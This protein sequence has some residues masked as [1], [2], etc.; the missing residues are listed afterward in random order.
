[1]NSL[2]NIRVYIEKMVHLMSKVL[3][4]DVLISDINHRIIGDGSRKGI[5]CKDEELE[6]L[7]NTSVI[8]LAIKE[9]RR[10]IFDDAK[11]QRKECMECKIKSE[12][13]TETI[14]AYPL[15]LDE[16]V[17]GG[18]GIY[19]NEKRQRDKIITDK[20]IMFE[21]IDAIQELIISRIRDENLKQKDILEKVNQILQPIGNGMI[22]EIIGNSKEIQ[23]VKKEILTFS[24]SRSN[25]LIQGESGTGKE[26]FA[27][28]MHQGSQCS[29]GPF[30]AV[31]CAAI[32]DNLLE[33]E[34]FGYEEGSFTGAIKGGRIGKFEVANGGT[35]FLDEIGELPIHLQPKLLRA[36]QEKKIQR[37]GGIDYIDTNIRI[38]AATN[39]NLFEMIET[40]EFREDLYYRLGV[41]PIHIPALRDRSNDIMSLLNHFLQMYSNALEKSAL[42]GFDDEVIMILMKYSWPGNVRELQN[43]VEYAV[44]HCLGTYIKVE[45][46]PKRI[47]SNKKNSLIEPRRLVDLEK[48]AIIDALKYYSGEKDAKTKAY[49]ALGMS[50]AMFYRKIKEYGIK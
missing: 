7:Q 30:I 35:L 28:A 33:S 29:N 27:R 31:N 38:I 41:I 49:V 46:L 11:N 44:N 42:R 5:V 23:E 8:S 15:I 2:T 13:K 3:D 45:D 19:S 43:T 34:L 10:I 21:F 32:P 20:T 50:K 16:D 22:N 6:V 1:M 36:I 39:K 25:V 18:F 17:I 4:M 24:K 9:K 12:C 48:D 37:V 40:R 14:I 47:I 26:M